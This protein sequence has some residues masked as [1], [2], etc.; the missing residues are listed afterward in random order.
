ME[1]NMVP[2]ESGN[3][4]VVPDIFDELE[5]DRARLVQHFRAPKW[6]APGYGLIAAA[7]VSIPAFPGE[8]TRNF[9]LIAAVIAGFLLVGNAYRATGIKISRFSVR[10]WAAFAVAVLGSLV[11]HSVSLGLAASGLP[12][13]I[14]APACA[15][16]VLVLWLASVMFASMRER[17]RNVR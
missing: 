12:W 4:R 1:N 15:A 7:Y 13:W 8:P 9:V 17:L 2:G 14:A 10:E 11:L 16:F 3:S 5:A 6:L